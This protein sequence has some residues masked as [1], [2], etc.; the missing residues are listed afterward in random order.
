VAWSFLRPVGVARTHLGR[1]QL[2]L[3]RYKYDNRAEGNA[4]KSF[5]PDVYYDF[6]WNNHEKYEGSLTVQLTHSPRPKYRFV[7][8]GAVPTHLY[9][10]D[11]YDKK[12]L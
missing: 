11:Q 5:I 2:E 9:E 1:H 12:Y 7:E 8:E 3:Y 6:L 10:E 4:A